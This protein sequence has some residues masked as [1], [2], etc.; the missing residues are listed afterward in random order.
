VSVSR[1]FRVRAPLLSAALLCGGCHL[2]FS[3]PAPAGDSAASQRDTGTHETTPDTRPLEGPRVP[4]STTPDASPPD[5]PRWDAPQADSG[6]L[7]PGTWQT[8]AKGSFLMG[9]PGDE[10]CRQSG[11]DQHPVVLTHGFEMQSTEVTAA[12][13][14]AVLAYTPS[15]AAPSCATCAVGNVTWSEAAAYCNALSAKKGLSACYACA[16]AGASAVC[17]E[18]SSWS[19]AKIYECAGYRLPTEA[20]WEYAYRAGTTSAFYDGPSSDSSCDSCTATE[21]TVDAIAWYCSNAGGLIHPVA[22]KAPNQWGLYDMGGNGAEWCNDWYV[23]A[24]GPLPA[25]DPWGATSGSSRA[26]R[27]GGYLSNGGNARAASR[28]PANAPKGADLTFR[29]VRTL[30]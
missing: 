21:K 24:L 25:I 7:V 20:E 23:A 13:F 6:P 8:I 10:L 9:S 26:T 14:A 28:Y 15:G 27:G 1:H 19:G 29:C 2:L 17:T 11:E 3:S 22:Q 18:A 30:P 5:G 12:Q 4:D 16:G